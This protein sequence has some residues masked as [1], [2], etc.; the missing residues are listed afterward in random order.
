MV[1]HATNKSDRCT[2]KVTVVKADISMHCILDTT[3]SECPA[4]T[5]SRSETCREQHATRNTALWRWLR[6]LKGMGRSGKHSRDRIYATTQ[7]CI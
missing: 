2:K 6:K 1:V 4:C 7:L 5:E 3:S